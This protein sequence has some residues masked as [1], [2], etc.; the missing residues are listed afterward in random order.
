[1]ARPWSCL[2]AVGLALVLVAATGCGGDDEQSDAGPAAS[3][4]GPAT[5]AETTAQT[6][7]EVPA[8][9][10]DEARERRRRDRAR[11]TR[12]RKRRSRLA[13]SVAGAQLDL[14]QL[15][16]ADVTTADK[17]G[18]VEVTLSKDAACRARA[19]DP[20]RIEAALKSALAFVQQVRL[21][22]RDT[23]APLSSYQ[24][25]SCVAGAEL[26]E[27]LVF[28]ANGKGTA[29][30]DAFTIDSRRWTIRFELGEGVVRLLVLRDGRLV[31]Q[32]GPPP[33]G[34]GERTLSDQGSF[35]IKIE[36]S[37]PWSLKVREQP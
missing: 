14:L 28:D 22:V 33:D 5:T 23:R 34:S 1:M 25:K 17:A 31:R 27:G 20:R 18:T 24:R 3:E 8:V 15:A 13:R 36:G 16:G 10:R 4:P 37:G 26:G 29:T 9:S 2:T 11:D 21:R 12:V 30:T 19:G 35:T 6:P 32:I 7:Y